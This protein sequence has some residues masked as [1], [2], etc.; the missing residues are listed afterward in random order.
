[1]VIEVLVGVGV[2]T[3]VGTGA[4]VEVDGIVVGVD[5]VALGL[6]DTVALGLVDTVALVGALAFEF[7][8]GAFVALA[9]EASFVA[10][11]ALDTVVV[12][13]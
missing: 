1:M 9:F 3:G 11:E 2:G 13:S 10:F 7:V 4:F 5:N 6:V 8:V 12:A